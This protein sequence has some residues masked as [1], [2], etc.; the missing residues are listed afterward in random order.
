MWKTTSRSSR[1]WKQSTSVS[2]RSWSLKNL[3]S[4]LL[5]RKTR[6]GASRSK[7]F[8][9]LDRMCARR[10]KC[11]LMRKLQLTLRKF[12]KLRR[13]SSF[14][15][16]TNKNCRILT[17]T[18]NLK[19]VNAMRVKNLRKCWKRKP[20]LSLRNSLKSLLLQNHLQKSQRK[21]QSRKKLLFR[22]RFKV[23]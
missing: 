13:K 16:C 1:D 18:F 23:F 5:S 21:S 8:V 10:W 20:A 11:S 12:F 17:K 4:R 9:R 3:K 22:K 6:S 14:K 15:S 19:V 2:R 7:L